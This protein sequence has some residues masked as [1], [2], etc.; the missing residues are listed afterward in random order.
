VRRGFAFAKTGGPNEEGN[1]IPHYPN[2]SGGVFLSVS[3]QIDC[4]VI[5]MN[6][7]VILCGGH[8]FVELNYPHIACI[9]GASR[10]GDL[11]GDFTRGTRPG[12]HQKTYTNRTKSKPSD[13]G[14]T[15]AKQGQTTN[16][17]LEGLTAAVRD[18]A[19]A[20]PAA[21]GLPRCIC[22]IRRSAVDLDMRI[23]VCT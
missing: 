15:M 14:Q 7:I 22:R 8:V 18:A 19:K 23:G 13:S 11:I 1:W 6:P 9:S 3:C 2:L 20:S 4:V 17:G 12:Q 10:C 16:R 21:K 5:A